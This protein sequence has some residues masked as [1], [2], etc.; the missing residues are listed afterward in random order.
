MRAFLTHRTLYL[1]AIALALATAAFFADTKVFVVTGGSMYPTYQDGQRVLVER[2]FWHL[3]G[4]RAGD[5]VVFDDP[6]GRAS[7]DIKRV[8]DT[9]AERGTYYLLGDNARNSTDSREWGSV[10]GSYILGRVIMKL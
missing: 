10:P 7:L 6:R 1:S 5:V 4:L 2:F 8:S 9:P 3:T